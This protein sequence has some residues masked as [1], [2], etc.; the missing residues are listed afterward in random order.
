MRTLASAN[1]EAVHSDALGP[2]MNW[3]TNVNR[4]QIYPAIAGL[5]LLATLLS[6]SFSV[7]TAN[8]EDAWMAAD[9]AGTQR[10][11]TFA[12]NAT[13]YAIVNLANAPDDTGVRAVWTAVEVEGTDPDTLIDETELTTGSGNL[14]FQLSND[15]LWPLGHYKVDLYLNEELDRALEFDVQP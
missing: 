7:S 14:V 2:H 11:T 6:C 8:I 10:T 12:Q 9:E 1:D 13:F 3:R 5:A 4:R 15:N